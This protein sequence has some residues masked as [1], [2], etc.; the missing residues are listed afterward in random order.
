MQTKKQ[1][2][3]DRVKGR[4]SLYFKQCVFGPGADFSEAC[5][6]RMYTVRHRL[7]ATVALLDITKGIVRRRASQRRLGRQRSGMIRAN[8]GFSV[9]VPYFYLTRLYKKCSEK[10]SP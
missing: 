8:T 4:F 1:T 10:I 6:I 7:E 5:I 2:F 9:F 3:L